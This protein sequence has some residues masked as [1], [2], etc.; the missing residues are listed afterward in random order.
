[1][2]P[3][4]LLNEERRDILREVDLKIAQARIELAEK[5]TATL[6]AMHAALGPGDGKVTDL[7][8]TWPKPRAVN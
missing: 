8:G 6:A 7:P 5:M 2:F 3:G 1:L 4:R